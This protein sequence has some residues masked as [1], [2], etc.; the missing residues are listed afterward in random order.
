MTCSRFRLWLCR[1]GWHTDTLRT[2]GRCDDCGVRA[3]ERERNERCCYH[4]AHRKD[5]M[6]Y[7]RHGCRCDLE[8]KP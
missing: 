6:F 7:Q 8:A 4:A 2:W 1:M 5:C 3:G